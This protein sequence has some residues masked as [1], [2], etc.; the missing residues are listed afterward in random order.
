MEFACVKR[1]GTGRDAAS[2]PVFTQ[3]RPFSP[4]FLIEVTYRLLYRLVAQ[5]HA[6][7]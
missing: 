5:R 1:L 7:A 6:T 4:G 3:Y 2:L